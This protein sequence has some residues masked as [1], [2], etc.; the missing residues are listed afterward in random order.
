MKKIVIFLVLV[1]TLLSPI[2]VHSMEKTQTFEEKVRNTQ[3]YYLWKINC[4]YE[5]LVCVYNRMEESYDARSLKFLIMCYNV[6]LI[7][8]NAFE[9]Q[10]QVA[11]FIIEQDK[12]RTNMTDFNLSKFSIELATGGAMIAHDSALE[13][14]VNGNLSDDIKKKLFEQNMLIFESLKDKLRLKTPT[15]MHE[16][17]KIINEILFDGLDSCHKILFPEFYSAS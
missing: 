11:H 15:Y 7:Q 4:T 17:V 16:Y 8:Q 5:A 2:S 3:W 1:S 9:K 14:I 12:Q 13:K 6:K 10:P